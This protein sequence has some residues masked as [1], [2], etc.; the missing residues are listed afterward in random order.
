MVVLPSGGENETL[1]MATMGHG[2]PPM[3]GGESSEITVK[4][5]Y[6]QMADM[7][8]M[9]GYD[10]V[11]KNDVDVT[12]EDLAT[13]SILLLGN[14]EQNSLVQ[15]LAP[16]ITEPVTISEDGFEVLGEAYTTEEYS[17]MVSTR[18]PRN[19]DY[20]IT[21]YMGNS[22]DAISRAQMIFFYGWDSFVIYMNGRPAGR[23]EWDMGPNR[24]Y[25]ELGD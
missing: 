15:T 14:W 6:A 7:M 13:H 11:V 25:F 8:T 17:I 23:G 18:N 10:V 4:D 16:A 20:D 21:W 22:P 24:L 2:G 9:S 3:G 5:F 12:E 1:E 19:T